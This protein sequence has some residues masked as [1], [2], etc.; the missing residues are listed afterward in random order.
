VKK[1]AAIVVL[2]FVAFF[3]VIIST[4]YGVKGSLNPGH[5]DTTVTTQLTFMNSWGGYDSKAGVI[6]E[7]L[8]DFQTDNP[9]VTVVNQTLSGDDFL[10]LIKEKFAT[11]D[12]PDVFGLWPGSDIRSLIAAGKVADLTALINSDPDWKNSFDSGM[13]PQVEQ[14]GKIYGLPVE[15]TFEGLFINKDLFK[16]YGVEVPQDYDGLIKAI[17]VFKAN[18]VIPIAFNCKPEGSYLYQNI[19]MSLGGKSVEKP[20]KNGRID[21]CYIQAMRI[22]KDLFKLGAFPENNECF[23]MESNTRDDLFLNEDAAMIVQGSW[24][25][26]KC[27]SEDVELVAFPRMSKA[28]KTNVV[29]GL[30]CGTFYISEKAWDDPNKREQAVKLLRCLTSR[31]SS[32][33]LAKQTDM[34]SNVDISSYNITYNSLTQTGLSLIKNADTLVGP[35]DSYVT[36][37]VWE[38]VIVNDFP[39]MLSG[40]ISPEDLWEKAIAA[41]AEEKQ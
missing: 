17:N 34:V 10:P 16:K 8:T 39:D 38:S 26:E 18:N 7:I 1:A 22:M 3:A 6:D 41:G 25:I 20:F 2:V 9:D 11:G 32:A 12:Q 33:K 14:D 13:W 37:S 36:R 31:E 35:P 40:N 15:I 27:K 21:N 5:N 23:S 30:G 28:S 4:F 19:A 29:Y 24:F